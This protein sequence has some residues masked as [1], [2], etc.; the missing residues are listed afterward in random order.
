M[1]VQAEHPAAQILRLEEWLEVRIYMVS[2]SVVNSFSGWS[3][4]WKKEV[5]NIHVWNMNLKE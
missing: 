5:S 2:W 1:G 4:I 3:R